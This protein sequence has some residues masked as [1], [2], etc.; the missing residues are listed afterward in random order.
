M[1]TTFREKQER[2]TTPKPPIRPSS[3]TGHIIFL[4]EGEILPPQPQTTPSLYPEVTIGT[5]TWIAINLNVS[6]Y[7]NGDIIPQVTD[8]TEWANLTTGAWCWY[9]ND[10]TNES[11]YGKLYNWHAVVDP[12]G[13][14]PDGYHV[15]TST[16]WSTISSYLTSVGLNGGAL[17]S[18]DVWSSPNTGATNS[19]GFGAIPGGFR[20]FVAGGFTAL[21]LAARF[22]TTE[23]VDTNNGRSYALNY[24]SST[25]STSAV[26]KKYGYSVRCIKD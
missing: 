10:P 17:K 22:W 8:P 12:R 11:I 6:V 20:S 25:L 5:Q 24:N 15:A 13:I 9:N 3:G 7:A 14:A 18:L 16:E 21:N 23:N 26:S 1:F 4:E 19:T 2:Y